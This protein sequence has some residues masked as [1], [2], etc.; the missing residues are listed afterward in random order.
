MQSV[1]IAVSEIWVTLIFCAMMYLFRGE[2]KQKKVT[3]ILMIVCIARLIS[4]AISWAFDGVPDLFWGMITLNLYFGWSY[5]LLMTAATAYEYMDFGLSLQTY[6]QTSA[7]LVAF[8]VGEIEI[9]ENLIE[10]HKKLERA[11]EEFQKHIFENFSREE[12][13]TVSG[14]Q[15][16]GLGMAITKKSVEMLGGTINVS[17]TEGVGSE[18]DVCLTF[19]LDGKKRSYEKIESLQGLRVLVADDDLVMINQLLF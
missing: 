1:Q 4:D 8:F 13:S 14:I 17:S 2:L 12:S 15:G 5:F 11:N 6:A 9:R 7:A 16:T 18:F 10:T 19:K 3:K